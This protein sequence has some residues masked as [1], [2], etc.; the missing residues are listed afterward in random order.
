MT[1]PDAT[2]LAPAYGF[3]LKNQALSIAAGNLPRKGALLAQYDPTK[4]EVVDYEP[5]LYL[6]KEQ[7]GAELGFGFPAHLMAKNWVTYGL[8]VPMWIVP[9]PETGTARTYELTVTVTTAVAGGI[10]MYI[11]DVLYQVAVTD[12]ESA[13]D[14]GDGIAAAVNA[15]D[16]CPFTAANAAGVV[17][18]TSKS[19]GLFS[20]GYLIEFNYEASQETAAGVT[21]TNTAETAGTLNPDMGPALAG[22]GLLSESNMEYFTD[23][24]TSN[25]LDET[26]LQ[27]CS[28]WNGIGDEAVGN[29]APS[30]MRPTRFLSVSTENNTAS[31]YDNM[32]AIADLNT[33]DRTNA[34]VGAPD[35]KRH[36]VEMACEILGACA[37]IA[38]SHP[39]QSYVGIPLTGHTG[40]SAER[41]TRDDVVRDTAVKSGISTTKV[42]D[43]TLVIDG[44]VTMYRPTTIAPQ[45]NIY[46]SFRNVA[47]T[48]NLSYFHRQVWEPNK[49][50]T[51]VADTAVLDP[52][53]KPYCM[54]L[55]AAKDLNNRWADE[56][57]AKAWIYNA[58]Y[59]KE[60]QEVTLRDLANGFDHVLK[61]VYSAE[62]VVSNTLVLGDI[63]LAVFA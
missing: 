36:P 15:D 4:T 7:V 42:I 22:M 57:E 5:K 21:I 45:N 59:T 9:V 31:G 14:I 32:L 19:T 51:I 49:N 63:S 24:V 53:E 46:R 38:Q 61:V 58:K 20:N 27:L 1:Y 60:T 48:Q 28:N 18:L 47:I 12:S 6:S 54:D 2:T 33:Y 62:G 43:G 23:C 17:T 30:V 41:W 52:I 39:H 10:Y 3:Q 13:S 40:T 56:S 8:S 50:K 26:T 25:G 29:Y 16:S 11:G 44:F 34:I 55:D 35:H 37:S